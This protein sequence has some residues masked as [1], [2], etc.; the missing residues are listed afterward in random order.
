M[1]EKLKYEPH[2]GFRELICLQHKQKK[3][4]SNVQLVNRH[5]KK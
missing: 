2:G 1:L 5:V 4:I 3:T